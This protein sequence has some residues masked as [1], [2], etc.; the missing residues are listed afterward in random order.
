MF[1]WYMCM[2]EAIIVM[3][4]QVHCTCTRMYSKHALLCHEPQNHV[5]CMG[6]GHGAFGM[7]PEMYMTRYSHAYV[8]VHKCLSSDTVLLASPPKLGTL[9]WAP[10]HIPQESLEL[11]YSALF[12][13]AQLCHLNATSQRWVVS[14]ESV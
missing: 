4:T 13:L 1:V 14:D 12:M 2:G 11:E 5:P 6:H 7:T 8:H 9:F 3:Y 10:H